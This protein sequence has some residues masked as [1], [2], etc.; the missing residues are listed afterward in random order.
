MKHLQPF[1]IYH[2][3]DLEFPALFVDAL[4]PAAFVQALDQ[5]QNA[6]RD[7]VAVR[8]HRLRGAVSGVD[9]QE[10]VLTIE[11]AD[12]RA[13][14][15]PLRPPMLAC[16]LRAPAPGSRI[17]RHAAVARREMCVT[18]RDGRAQQHQKLSTGSAARRRSNWRCATSM[19]AV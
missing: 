17:I 13:L 12:P 2:T 16:A 4:Q 15:P 9:V 3:A 8:G 10:K 19:S 11:P 1:P 5:V 7:A 6:D 18:S 14:G